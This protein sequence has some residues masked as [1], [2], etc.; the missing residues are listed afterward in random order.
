MRKAMIFASLLVPFSF[1]M[2][3]AAGDAAQGKKQFA[4]CM[5]CHTVEAKGPNKLGPN[6]NG[7]FGKKAGTNKKDFAYSDA[8]KKADV[9]WDEAKLEEYI[10]K[11]AAMV[12]GGKMAFAGVSSPEIRANIIAYLKEATK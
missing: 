5:A 3:N 2:A 7:I 4:Y 1:G 9:V 12:P 6:L 11:P 8:M 10:T